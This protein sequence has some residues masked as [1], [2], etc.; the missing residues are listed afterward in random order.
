MFP[1]SAN[2][3]LCDECSQTCHL[4]LVT[5][6]A[7]TNPPPG[8]EAAGASNKEKVAGKTDPG[9]TNLKPSPVKKA[10]AVKEN[11]VEA[12]GT[13]AT[14]VPGT[15]LSVPQSEDLSS[16]SKSDIIAAKIPAVQTVGGSE[17][18]KKKKKEKKEKKEKK[19][20]SSAAGKAVKASK[21]KDKENKKQKASQ[22]RKLPGEDGAVGQPK[23]KKRKGQASEEVPKKKKKKADDLEKQTGSKEKKKTTKSEYLCAVA[24]GCVC[25]MIFAAVARSA[26]GAGPCKQH[27]LCY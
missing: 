2:G 20:P 12:K 11:D 16:G 15:L 26:S 19:K 24:W 10:L 9:Y 8:Q 17:E 1:F 6:S 14:P 4:S 22:K 3:I 18:K 25:S 21:S 13:H 5:V 27:P 7:E 23:E